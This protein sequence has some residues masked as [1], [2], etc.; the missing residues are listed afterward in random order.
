[1][2]N[3]DWNKNGDEIIDYQQ[4]KTGN[5][6]EKRNIRDDKIIVAEVCSSFSFHFILQTMNKEHWYSAEETYK[7]STCEDACCFILG[8]SRINVW[9][10]IN[11]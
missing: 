4:E 1:M 11:F 2:W 10:V 9:H 7:C 6:I 8:K 5:I 3:E